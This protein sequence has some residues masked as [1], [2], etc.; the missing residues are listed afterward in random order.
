M[1]S[2][3]SGASATGDPDTSASIAKD[4]QSRKGARMGSVRLTDCM[5][6]VD[7]LSHYI[8]QLIGSRGIEPSDWLSS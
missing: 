6:R 2:E 4:A 8:L 1:F 3:E 7:W 5:L